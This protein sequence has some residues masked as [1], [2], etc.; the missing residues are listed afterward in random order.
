MTRG[1]L[2]GGRMSATMAL[3]VAAALQAAPEQSVSI[4]IADRGDPRFPD[5]LM[6]R[7]ERRQY[8]TRAEKKRRL[9]G[10]RP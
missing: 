6:S 5:D 10:L 1:V 7:A 9:K 8:A 2:V 3:A 4:K